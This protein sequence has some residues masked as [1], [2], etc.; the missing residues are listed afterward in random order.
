MLKRQIV[1]FLIL[2]I[3]TGRASFAQAPS[4]TVTNQRSTDMAPKGSLLADI[5]CTVKI[6]GAPKTIPL[7]AATPLV[8]NLKKGDNIIEAVTEDKKSSFKTTVKGEVGQTV[9][10]E[11]SFFD[12][13]HFTDYIKQGNLPMLEMAIKKDPNLLTSK[14]NLVT[15][16][17]EIAI[18]SSQPDVVNFFLD[19]GASY[20]RPKNMYPLHKSIMFASSVASSKKKKLA[21]DSILVDL[22]LRKGCDVNEKDEVGN[23]PLH[24]AAQYGKAELVKMLVE[25][26]ADINARNTFADTPLKLAENKGYV[27]IIDYLKSKGGLEK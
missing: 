1:F 13:K 17:L 23:T 6:N 27:T 7:K 20:T 3:Y 19:N 14:N 5:D 26:G 9:P 8:V 16:P 4:K 24:C 25:R 2:F 18:T 15:S 21:A 22:F 10:V 12:D 11:I